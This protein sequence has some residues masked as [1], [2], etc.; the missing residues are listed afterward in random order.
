MKRLFIVVLLVGLASPAW[1]SPEN[2]QYYL[3]VLENPKNPDYSYAMGTVAGIT[4]MLRFNG[5]M[6]NVPSACT[7]DKTTHGQKAQVF[8]NWAKA[9]PKEWTGH[10]HIGMMTAVSEAWPC[11]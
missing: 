5:V 1:A 3:Q 4:F 6:K 7:P 8:I 2:V 11:K 10:G 9:N